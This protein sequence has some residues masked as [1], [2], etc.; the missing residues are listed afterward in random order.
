[1][2]SRRELHIQINP[3]TAIR[4]PKLDT[5][6]PK[7]LMEQTR[8]VSRRRILQQHERIEKYRR[9]TLEFVTLEQNIEK[10]K[11]AYKMSVNVL[12]A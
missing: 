3:A 4:E 1:M 12:I 11:N 10:I 8:Q 5:R 2:G 7:F 6:I 9:D